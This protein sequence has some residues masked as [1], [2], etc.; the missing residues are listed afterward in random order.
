MSDGQWVY[1]FSKDRLAALLAAPP[2]ELGLRRAEWAAAADLLERHASL[3]LVSRE[4][5]TLASVI[6]GV[7]DS[8]GSG[9]EEDEARA[10]EKDAL[11]GALE[12]ALELERE[13]PDPAQTLF[14]ELAWTR[15]PEPDAILAALVEAGIL[16]LSPPLIAR[17]LDELRRALK[18]PRNAELREEARELLVRPL[19]R[20]QARGRWVYIHDD[21][22]RD[23]W[24]L[25]VT[26]QSVEAWRAQADAAEAAIGAGGRAS[27][28]QAGTIS[29]GIAA[30]TSLAATL[31]WEGRDLDAGA[32][33]A[34]L[35]PLERVLKQLER[36]A[37][38]RITDEVDR[39]AALLEDGLRLAQASPR[40]NPADA[41]RRLIEQAQ[42][43]EA[44][45]YGVAW[46]AAGDAF[47]AS[48]PPGSESRP[49]AF[50]L[51]DFR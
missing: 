29:A 18:K 10:E 20:A 34:R 42:G 7:I 41:P 25:A 17:L 21:F 2:E 46:A 9:D 15:K 35:A 12:A 23:S 36:D 6:A 13:S 28:A 8:W 30:L 24:M 47:M 51:S 50:A 33:R 26:E 14:D 37:R 40:A 4:H 19:V 48:P 5:W 43:L 39:A 38:Q 3:R 22:W 16:V 32:A 45:G 27:P 1:S 49:L 44:L 31:A 11:A